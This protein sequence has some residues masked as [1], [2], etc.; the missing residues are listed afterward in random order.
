MNDREAKKRKNRKNPFIPH[1]LPPENINWQK[2]IS[3]IGEANRGIA[4]YDGLLTGL[5]NPDILISP[6]T[7]KESVISSRI[8]GTQASLEDVLK[9]EAGVKEKSESIKRDVQE[10]INYRKAL[11]VAT[12]E[13]K[14]RKITLNL[15][16][17]M[18]VILMSN[19]R[20]KNKTPGQFRKTQNWIGTKGTPIEKARFVPPSPLIVYE[21]M[22]K[23][24]RFIHSN[25]PDRIVQIAIIHAQFEMIHPFLDGNGRIGRLLIPLFLYS[26]KLLKKPVF[27]ISE[28]FEE[29]RDEYY[30]KLLNI[31][32]NDDW[33]GWIEFF[34]K[35]VILQAER[36]IEK[37]TKIIKLY[38]KLKDKFIETTHSQFAVPLLDAFFMKPVADSTSVLKIA[39]IPN[40][41]TGNALLK[42]LIK[43]RLIRIL[44]KGKG[45]RPAVYV[46]PELL[47]IIE[48][49]EIL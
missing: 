42:K 6:L 29:N 40:R 37:T 12:E 2:I 38:G 1:E 13:L 34:L 19:V 10:I 39:K 36:N 35:A 49:R 11:I 27:Y 20:G 8:E 4:K 16:K 32:G 31:T 41:I 43:T 18:H 28:F 15:I 48:D 33:Q 25:F 7:V 45:R 17:Q 22:E 46:L 30:D 47:N 5:I 21:H 24:E 23:L 9:I 26:N 44:I 14:H 3:L